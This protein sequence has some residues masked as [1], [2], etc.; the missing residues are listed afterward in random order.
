MYAIALVWRSIDEKGSNDVPEA[1]VSEEERGRA[2]R[3]G[4]DPASLERPINEKQ[5]LQYHAAGYH[6][7]TPSRQRR[8]GSIRRAGSRSASRIE[9]LEG[10]SDKGGVS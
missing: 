3:V 2:G 4:E 9:G 1:V 7:E 5:G 6:T 8:S 10:S